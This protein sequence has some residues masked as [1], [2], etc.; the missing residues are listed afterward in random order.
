MNGKILVNPRFRTLT[1][2]LVAAAL[3]LGW[4]AVKRAV[5]GN[6][7]LSGNYR[8]WR[9]NLTKATLPVRR[10]GPQPEDPDSYPPITYAIHAPLGALPLWATATLWYALN[11]ACSFYLWRSAR[12]WLLFADAASVGVEDGRIRHAKVR[13]ISLNLLGRELKLG[14]DGILGLVILAILPSW[15]G[16]LLLG[17]NTLFLMTL[18]WGAFQSARRNSPWLAGALLNLATALKVLPAVFLLPFIFHRNYRVCLAFVAT[19]LALLF[20]L[21]SLYFGPSTN[22]DFHLKWLRYATQG[23]ENRPADPRDPNTLR[24]SIR[25][26]NQSIEAVLAR[27]MMDV[28]IHNRPDAPRVNLLSVSA[29]SWRRV[30][31]VATGLCVILGLWVLVRKSRDQSPASSKPSTRLGDTLAETYVVLCLLQL[32]ISPIVWSHYYVW[33]FWPLLIVLVTACEGRRSGF[34]IYLA[35]IAALPLIAVPQFRAIGIHLWAT[36]AIYVWI[37]WPILFRAR[38]T[39]DA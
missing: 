39:G 31:S 25:Y 32:F 15:I 36:L 5:N 19:G 18:T 13:E 4:L 28:P 17:Q 14:P 22:L 16:T 6:A 10:D 35:W 26:H 23:S 30:K 2:F 3:L 33:L 1:I 27:L 20:G 8:H 11:L 24:A 21:G 7:D 12:Q 29:E 38:Q 37:C 9:V 34:F